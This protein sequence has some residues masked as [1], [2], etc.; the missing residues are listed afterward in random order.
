MSVMASEELFTVVELDDP[1]IVEASATAL[2][3]A[4]ADVGRTMDEA[5]STWGGLESS[6]RAPETDVLLTGLDPA[7]G[8]AQELARAGVEAESAVHAYAAELRDLQDRRRVL[9]AEIEYFWTTGVPDA[10]ADDWEARELRIAELQQEC[11]AL[12]EAKDAAQNRCAAALGAI[13]TSVSAA[14]GSRHQ[15]PEASAADEVPQTVASAV[16][17]EPGEILPFDVDRGVSAVSTTSDAVAKSSSSMRPVQAWA[18][19]KVRDIA[20]SGERGRR[21]MASLTG[22]DASSAADPDGRLA[23]DDARNPFRPAHGVKERL[24]AVRGRFVASLSEKNRVAKPGMSGRFSA[25]SKIAKGAGRAG[26]FLT[27]ATGAVGQWKEDSAAHPDMEWHEKGTRAATVGG[28]TAAGAWAGTK[29]GAAAGA[30]IGSLFPG[31]GTAI[32]AVVGGV[33]GG[34]AGSAL[35]KEFGEGLKEFAGDA[36][37][38][39]A[40]GAEKVWDKVTSLF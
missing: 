26:T 28:F 5:A 33:V 18:P 13:T 11:G 35:G 7:V 30:A 32:G 3:T 38:A 37:D 19:A 2:K 20:A 15:V 1:D 21:A 27:A 36:A 16:D 12:A 17:A 6:Y 8:H 29:T 4:T 39:V 40:E 10:A 34:I 14:R 24:S 23:A 31:P 9:L 25:A 22:W